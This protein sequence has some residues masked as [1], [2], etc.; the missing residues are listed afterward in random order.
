MKGEA[1]MKKVICFIS[2]L[3]CLCCLV[4]CDIANITRA[5]KEQWLDLISDTYSSGL[6]YKLNDDE[7]SYSV[8]GIGLCN[9]SDVVIPST[10]NGLP[11]TNIA[12]NAFQECQKL[13]S[14]KISDSVT[15]IGMYAFSYCRSL[16][17]IIIS[18]S[19]TTIVDSP[20]EGCTALE[21]IKVNKANPSY[22]SI[23]GNLYSKDG[24]TLIR[25]AIGKKDTSFIIPDSVT[26][27]DNY[28]FR[29]S[30]FLE[31]VEMSDSVTSIGMYAFSW[32]SSLKSIKLSKSIKEIP[33]GMF[34]YCTSL[35]DVVIPDSVKSIG[36]RAFYACKSLAEITIPYGVT[37]INNYTFSNCESLKSVNIP[38]SVTEIGGYAFSSCKSLTKIV[39]PDS[40]T[41]IDGFAFQYC[42]SLKIFCK[43][44][45]L[46]SNWHPYWKPEEV[47]VLWGYIGK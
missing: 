33:N 41:R 9:D 27:I 11:V 10:H 32:C 39:I 47:P 7:K 15:S 21:N 38:S 40:V 45:S 22:S 46:S 43:A 1:Y 17:T 6:A 5:I 26:S 13:K 28:A 8:T 34:N 31:S 24:T 18:Q 16:K 3:L 19:V 29:N 44:K 25:Y 30:Q 36:G 37:V 20:F 23:D 42:S 4:S 2:L 35:T 14:V 12:H